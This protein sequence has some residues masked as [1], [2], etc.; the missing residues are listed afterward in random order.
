MC[1]SL[2]FVIFTV[3]GPYDEVVRVILTMGLVVGTGLVSAMFQLATFPDAFTV[4][5]ATYL[6]ML[7][8]ANDIIVAVSIHSIANTATFQLFLSSG[9]QTPPKIT[10]HLGKL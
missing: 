5:F 4:S 10:P 7:L 8:D 2:L 6:Q 1:T 3:Y 9:I